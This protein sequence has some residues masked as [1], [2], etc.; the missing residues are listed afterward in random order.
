MSYHCFKVWSFQL[1]RFCFFLAAVVDFRNKQPY[2]DDNILLPNVSI[3]EDSTIQI[4]LK[5]L[6]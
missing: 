2:W 4:A 1:H 5:Y 6:C 3:F